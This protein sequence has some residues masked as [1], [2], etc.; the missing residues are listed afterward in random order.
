MI[1][2]RTKC[3]LQNPTIIVKHTKYKFTTQIKGFLVIILNPQYYHTFHVK[4]RLNND[5][6][7]HSIHNHSIHNHSIHR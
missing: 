3:E 6:H 4:T 7:N 2:L 1:L 5:I